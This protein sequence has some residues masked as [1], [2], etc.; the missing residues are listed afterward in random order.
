MGTPGAIRVVER[1][2]AWF[3]RLWRTNL[4]NSL[5][6]PML[7]L[8]GLGVGV[9]TLV[10][11]NTSSTAALGG[12]PY[13]RFVAP[14]LL[15]TTAMA[16]AFG[17][18]AWPVLGNFKWQRGYVAMSFTPLKAI[19]MVV[20][21]LLWLVLRMLAATCAVTT[22]L[23]LFPS[24]RTV[25]LLPSIAFA[26]ISG[27]ALGM[28]VTAYSSYQERE[29][30]FVSLSR[31]LLIPLFL[32]GGAFFPVD[33][34]PLVIRV[35]VK[36]FPLWHGTVLSRGFVTGTLG[37]VELVGHLAYLSVWIAAGTAIATRKFARRL[38]S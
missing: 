4:L 8:L 29:V 1:N 30:G 9:G 37:T 19:D 35:T 13:E 16:I 31:F 26:T 28:V 34:L 36:A 32:F 5:L 18:S 12:L 33:Q 17:E 2:L 7:Y 22:A 25:R 10:N 23:M 6:Q 27:L 11:R 20:G 3:R 15:C 14:G 21:H 24:V 38:G